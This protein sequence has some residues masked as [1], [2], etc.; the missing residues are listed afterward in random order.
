M[1]TGDASAITT[2]TATIAGTVNP[3]LRAATDHFE[4]GPTTAY[5][6]STPDTSAGTGN[7]AA[8]ASTALTGLAPG[9]TIHYRL[10]AV[11][12]DGTSAG[13]DRTFVVDKTP[14]AVPPPAPVLS[15][16]SL[17]NAVFAVAPGPTAVIAAR[18]RKGTTFRYTLSSDATVTIAIARAASGRIKGTKCVK[19]T[20]KLRR[21]KKCTRFVTVGTL[22]RASVAGRTR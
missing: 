10:V 18:A 17:T 19:P 15:E 2:T 11:N 20:P 9:S 22:T 6:T 3:N 5:G 4:F 21:A 14:D 13:A 8:A 7:A 16:V 12:A 1:V